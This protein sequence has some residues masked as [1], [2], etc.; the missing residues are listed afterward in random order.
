MSCRSSLECF[1]SHRSMRTKIN[2]K[3][4]RFLRTIGPSKRQKLSYIANGVLIYTFTAHV[5]S[6]FETRANWQQLCEVHI[7]SSLL[8]LL[9]YFRISQR[10]FKFVR[11]SSRLLFRRYST[12]FFGVW[13]G[14]GEEKKKWMVETLFVLLSHAILIAYKPYFYYTFANTFL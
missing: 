3:I 9:S 8:F 11:E 10:G 12:H 14:G 4:R 5:S 1:C 7:R 13:R 2:R 6:K